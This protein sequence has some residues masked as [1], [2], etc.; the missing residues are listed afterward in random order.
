MTASFGLTVNK[1]YIFSNSKVFSAKFGKNIN[2]NTNSRKR[3]ID[4]SLLF[5]GYK[6]G[7]VYEHKKKKWF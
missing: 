1:F 5:V 6:R 2:N 4:V 7:N 3:K